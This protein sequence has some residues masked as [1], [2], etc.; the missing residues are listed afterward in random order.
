MSNASAADKIR[1]RVLAK[2]AEFHLKAGLPGRTVVWFSCGAASAVAT[3]LALLRFPDLVIANN[4]VK[5][6]HPDN[7]RFLADCTRWWGRPVEDVSDTVYGA[8]AYEVIRRRKFIKGPNGAQCTVKLKKEVR[9]AWQ[10]P[11]D[12]HVFGYDVDEQHRIDNLIDGNPELHTWFPLIEMQLAKTDCKAMIERAGIRLP[13]MYEMGYLNNN[14]IGCVKGGAGYWNKIRVDF[15]ERF[16]EMAKIEDQLG[17]YVNRITIDGKVRP[18]SLRQLPPD[19]G[20]PVKDSP[21]ACSIFC[22]F[23]ENEIRNGSVG[24]A[25]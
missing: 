7:A 22:H 13:V 18:V 21:G 19:A 16:E 24:G 6:E 5:E 10:R 25:P 8:S 23:A 11:S 1:N 12:L 14:C 15:P 2:D 20:D 9:E 4:T 17:Y 3:K